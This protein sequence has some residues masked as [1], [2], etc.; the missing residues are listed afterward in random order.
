MKHIDKLEKKCRDLLRRKDQMKD[1]AMPTT[2]IER[3]MKLILDQINAV[4]RQDLELRNRLDEQ[5]LE[6][7]SRIL[8]QEPLLHHSSQ[9]WFERKRL[10]NQ[11]KYTVVR[12]EQQI[13]RFTIE[14]QKSI[15]TL[16]KRLLE[17]WNMHD[18]L[19]ENG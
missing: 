18:Q 10:T 14:N 2:F 6:I 16:Q 7:E 13:F 11:L 5:R 4:R 17:L 3:E 15:H 12:L 19:Q 1:H 9:F 8:N